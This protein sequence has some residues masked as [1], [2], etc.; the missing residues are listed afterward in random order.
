M[1]RKACADH[2][3][4][5]SAD[6]KDIYVCFEKLENGDTVAPK[7]V[8]GGFTS[9]PPNGF[10][11]I[12]P[13]LCAL[14][15]EVVVLRTEVSQMREASN[16][17]E[18]ALNAAYVVAQDVTEIK[19]LVQRALAPRAPHPPP[20]EDPVEQIVRDS[21]VSALTPDTSA[22]NVQTR[23]VSNEST[24]MFQSDGFTVVNNRPYANALRRNGQRANP[25]GQQFS[26]QTNARGHRP[27]PQQTGD[28][29]QAGGN[30]QPGGG[31]RRT[32]IM[33]T[34]PSDLS[35]ASEERILD[36]FVGGC[37]SNSTNDTITAYCS[38]NCVLL[39]K[40]EDLRSA[41]EWT[42]S[43]KISVKLSDK[44][45]IMD[46]AFW[47][48]GVFVRKFFRSRIRQEL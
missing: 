46:A 48:Q 16:K 2:Q 15:D 41:S 40:C 14:R 38:N 4:P 30:R 13:I 5:T 39:K 22:E 21:S 11:N 32:V 45:K 6:L 19:A 9:F 8:G 36:I 26:A 43:Y 20:G 42:K 7:F 47:P 3:N 29:Q 28:N 17:D 18:R 24:D 10:E 23:P 33:G 44:E 12:A 35:I 34:R 27:M 25:A 1:K 37:G 31:R